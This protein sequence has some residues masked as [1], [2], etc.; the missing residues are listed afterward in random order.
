MA[1][2]KRLC[3]E[4]VFSEDESSPKRKLKNNDKG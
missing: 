2:K 1:P 3:S 4:A